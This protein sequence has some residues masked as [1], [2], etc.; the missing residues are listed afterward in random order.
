MWVLQGHNVPMV[1]KLVSAKKWDQAMCI[2]D[3]LLLVFT[4]MPTVLLLHPSRIIQLFLII[5]N[6]III[7]NSIFNRIFAPEESLHE[8][9]QRIKFTSVMPRSPVMLQRG[10]HFPP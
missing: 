2:C 9:F 6:A 8:A 1:T 7:Q 5:S 4:Q 10:H 3:H